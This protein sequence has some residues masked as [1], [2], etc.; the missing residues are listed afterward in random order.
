MIRVQNLYASCNHLIRLGLSEP[1]PTF[2]SEAAH[3]SIKT[4]LNA[5]V[6]MDSISNLSGSD[7]MA[8]LFNLFPSLVEKLIGFSRMISASA[9]EN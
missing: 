4:L 3:W 9:R 7:F 5:L 1:Q 8:A 6:V 2:N